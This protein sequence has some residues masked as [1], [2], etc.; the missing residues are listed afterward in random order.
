MSS[1][2]PSVMLMPAVFFPS[3]WAAL[4]SDTSWALSK[5]ALSA[6]IVGI[7]LRALANPS[8]ARDSFPGVDS[9]SFD[10]ADAISIS[11]L[12]PPNTTRLSFTTCER[13]QRASWSER[14]ASS[15][16]CWVAP[17]STMV[18]A[19][20]RGTPENLS[21]LSSPIITSSIR[22]HVPSRTSSG[23]ANVD[24]I[25]PPVTRARRSMPSKSACSMAMT[26]ASAN[27]CSG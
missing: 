16:I 1:T 6:M 23:L 11:E 2:Q 18:Q 25:S 19:S 9:A 12:P 14:S 4:S 5:P 17:R 13:T 7:C 27:S 20:P 21:S 10:T 26:P 22:S 8:M 24:T 3:E 15:R